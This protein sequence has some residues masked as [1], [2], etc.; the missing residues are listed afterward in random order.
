MGSPSRPIWGNEMWGDTCWEEASLSPVRYEQRHLCSDCF[1]PH[2]RTRRQSSF[3]MM[4]I[5][6]RQSKNVAKTWVFVDLWTIESIWET[7]LLV[8]FVKPMDFVLLAVKQSYLLPSFCR[9]PALRNPPTAFLNL[10]HFRKPHVFLFYL[11][12]YFTT[13]HVGQLSEKSFLLS[14]WMS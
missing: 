14:P 10:S 6:G 2:L 1:W 13:T 8:A 4:W 5:P 12:S 11:F 3:R 9:T 7:S